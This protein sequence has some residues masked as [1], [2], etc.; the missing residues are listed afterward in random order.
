MAWRAG[1]QAGGPALAVARRCLVKDTFA[2]RN[3]CALWRRITIVEAVELDAKLLAEL[4]VDIDTLQR[5]L[6]RIRSVPRPLLCA[7]EPEDVGAVAAPRVPV[8]V[9]VQRVWGCQR[10]RTPSQQ[11][12]RTAVQP[13]RTAA[14]PHSRTASQR[15]KRH[16][17][18]SVTASQTRAVSVQAASNQRARPHQTAKRS[19]SF[20]FRPCT[21]SSAL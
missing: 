5:A 20:I 1:R 16:S 6:Q 15:H 7:R 17:V 19:Q 18:T 21:T 14:Q 12:S 11:H 4:K 10:E 13:R 9:V 2:L 3:R 8:A